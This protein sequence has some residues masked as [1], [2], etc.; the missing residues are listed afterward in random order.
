[1]G[2]ALITL[3]LMPSSPEANL[4]EI[5]IK[6][7]STIEEKQGKKVRFE[8]EPIAFGLKAIKAFFDLDEAH[9]LEP[10]ENS[11]KEIENINSVQVVDM[12]RAFG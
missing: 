6:A 9:E 10:I 3:K 1:M 8:E 4:E 2:I 11:L 7:K 5:K 12:R